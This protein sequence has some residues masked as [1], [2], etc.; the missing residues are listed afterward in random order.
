MLKSDEGHDVATGEKYEPLGA[1]PTGDISYGT[2][3][4]MQVIEV[5]DGR[6]APAN[7]VPTDAE[8]IALYNSFLAYAGTY[9]IAGDIISHHIDASW[10]QAW[11][12]TTVSRHFKIDDK[13]LRIS[14][15]FISGYSGRNVNAVL[16]WTKVE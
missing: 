15:N 9:S 5:M 14:G 4:R 13:T 1:H 2:D 12:G 7:L 10:N 6:K 11:I 8:R 3:C 16:T